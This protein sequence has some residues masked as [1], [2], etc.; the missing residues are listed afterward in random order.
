MRHALVFGVQTTGRVSAT[1]N[2]VRLPPLSGPCTV[3]LPSFI[4]DRWRIHLHLSP[5]RCVLRAWRKKKKKKKK[6]QRWNRVEHPDS[7]HS[8]S[9]VSEFAFRSRLHRA[10]DAIRCTFRGGA[11]ACDEWWGGNICDSRNFS[12][13]SIIECVFKWTRI[14]FP[15]KR[16]VRNARP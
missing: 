3:L 4:A 12:L 9:I 16:N 11:N 1:A 2:D 14:S 6:K 8:N 5:P 10:S 15:A 13:V 7:P